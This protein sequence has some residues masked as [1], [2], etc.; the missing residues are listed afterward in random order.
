MNNNW[1]KSEVE[2]N[3][4]L[5]LIGDVLFSEGGSTYVVDELFQG[6]FVATDDYS[7]EIFYF[8]ELQ[9]GWSI[10]QKSKDK[11][12]LERRFRYVN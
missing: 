12:T 9:K 5:I 11:N 2:L 3:Q 6:G 1:M 10:S 8:N 7:T 4:K